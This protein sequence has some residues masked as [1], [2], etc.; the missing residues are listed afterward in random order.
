MVY[1]EPYYTSKIVEL[2]AKIVDG[3]KSLTVLA[4]STIFHI[5]LGSEYSSAFSSPCYRDSSCLNIDAR[6][7]M[8]LHKEYNR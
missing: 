8:T 7:L 6:M 5:L 3:R 2:F 1:L 4:N